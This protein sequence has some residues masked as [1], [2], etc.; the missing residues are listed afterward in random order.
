MHMLY[1][2]IRQ[3]LEQ[4][5]GEVVAID[6]LDRCADDLVPVG[7][8]GQGNALL[9]AAYSMPLNCKRLILLGL[10]K[11]DY[12]GASLAQEHFTFT[13]TAKEWQ[14]VFGNQGDTQ[15]YAQMKRAATA[16]MERPPGA[17]WLKTDEK[18]VIRHWFSECSY[19]DGQ[20]TVRMIF[21]ESIRPNLRNL[22]HG[23]DYTK[24]D[25]Q[26][27]CALTS[28]YSI[29]LYEMCRQFKDKGLVIRTIEDFRRTF[30][31]ESK[32]PAFHDLKKRIIEP[33]VAEIRNNTELT[34]LKWEPIKHGPRIV[35]LRFSFKC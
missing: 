31:L 6:G 11:I 4:G 27:V 24:V 33:S 29:R 15:T 28:T 16:L 22:T 32:Y 14:H 35:R 20:G 13:V 21:C 34:S 10:S 5:M 19:Y 26:A 30:K 2:D 7:T 18:T 23:G 3:S 1:A 12:S 8:Y 17:I 9:N 25:L